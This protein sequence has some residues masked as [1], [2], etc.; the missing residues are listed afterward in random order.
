MNSFSPVARDRLIED[1][2]SLVRA[3]DSHAKA[4][5]TGRAK[6][7]GWAAGQIEEFNVASGFGIEIDTRALL[8]RA[9][10]STYVAIGLYCAIA[11]R[12]AAERERAGSAE[13]EDLTS[14]VIKAIRAV[15]RCTNVS[16]FLALD[17]EFRR[18]S[19]LPYIRMDSVGN[20]LIYPDDAEALID[21]I[22]ELCAP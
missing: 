12:L 6:A 5:G 15:A 17:V 4:A 10:W 7:V 11:V 22:L 16:Y 2:V 14:R 19:A 8:T 1:V 21:D 18:V 3:Y 9:G 13:M 20:C